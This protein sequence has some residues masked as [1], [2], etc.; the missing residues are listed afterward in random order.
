MKGYLQNT[1]KKNL[2]II[3]TSCIFLFIIIGILLIPNRRKNTVSL[4]I[5][6]YSSINTICELATL[7]SFYHNVAMYEEKPDG[8]NK[9]FNDVLFWP[10]G[11][12]SKVGYKQF[13]L[14]YSGIV[15][16]GIKANKIQ[17]VGPN[18]KGIVDVYMP[19]AEV[20]D[21]SADES[22]LSEPLSEN[23][24]FTTITGREKTDAFAKAQSAMRQEAEQDQSLLKRAKENAKL[25]FEQYIINTGKEMGVDY[26]INWIQSPI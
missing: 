17:I 14:E 22:T 13:W 21:V 2:P 4:N 18:E 3:I 9:F 24:W 16:I 11:G 10:F 7:K 26:S 23:G 15:E 19:D 6:E 8:G 20:L 25:L 1:I 12:Y 5:S